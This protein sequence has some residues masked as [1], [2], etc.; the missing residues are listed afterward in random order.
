MIDQAAHAALLRQFEVLLLEHKDDRSAAGLAVLQ[1]MRGAGVTCWTG[2]FPGLDAWRGHRGF[3]APRPTDATWPAKVFLILAE[4]LDD[5]PAADLAELVLLSA[6][7]QTKE[8]HDRATAIAMP[9]SERREDEFKASQAEHMARFEAMA[10][11]TGVV[12]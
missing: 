1:A 6:K 5:V 4:R 11:L 10:R 8:G 9:W 12:S 7:P 3:A 2:L